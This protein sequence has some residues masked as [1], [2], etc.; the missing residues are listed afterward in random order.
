MSGSSPESLKLVRRGTHEQHIV[1]V[2]RETLRGEEGVVKELWRSCCA[3][4][5]SAQDAALGSGR[6]L[7][8]AQGCA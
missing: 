3:S 6:G 4:S 7:L 5:N 8:A 2:V 1:W